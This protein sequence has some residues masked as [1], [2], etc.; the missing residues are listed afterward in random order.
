MTTR[1]T[2]PDCGGVLIEEDEQGIQRYRCSVGHAFSPH[3]LQV[4][5][6][7]ALERALW[8]AARIVDDRAALMRDMARRAERRGQDRSRRRY[9]ERAA[10]MHEHAVVLRA[11]VERASGDAEDAVEELA[12]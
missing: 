10:E 1:L 9:L 5:H 3:S 4:E 7:H 8:A 11:L 6:A 12:E 2:C